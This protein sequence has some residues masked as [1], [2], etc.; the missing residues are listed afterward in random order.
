MEYTRNIKNTNFLKNTL[1][2][3]SA[4]IAIIDERGSI[5]AV[6]TAWKKFAK[7]NNYIGNDHGVGTNYFDI[8]KYGTTE[9]K[10]VAKEIVQ[11][12]KDV[13]KD[14]NKLYQKEYPCNS[15]SEKRWFI[16]KATR[17]DEGHNKRAVIAHENITQQKQAI[18]DLKKTEQKL[19]LHFEQT[20]LAIIEWDKNFC[21]TDW[22]PQAEKIFGYTKKFAIGK[23]ASELL[24]EK[25]YF[26]DVNREGKIFLK[27]KKSIQS[28]IPTRTKNG[29]EIICQWYNTPL[30]DP[31][32]EVVGSASMI[33]DITER[34]NKDKAIQ[35]LNRKLQISN[36]ELEDF[37][38]VASHD[39][40][41]PLRKVHMFSDRIMTKYAENLPPEGQDYFKRM[42][43]AVTRMHLL[44]NDLLAFSRVASKAKPYEKVDLNE[45][46]NEVIDDLEVRIKETNTTIDKTD[47]PTI[48]A[49]AMQMRQLIQNLISNAIKFKKKNASPKIKLSAKIIKKADHPALNK[50]IKYCEISVA[51]NGIGFNVKYLDKIFTVFQRLHGNNEYEGSGIGLAVCRKIAERHGGSITATSKEGK[52]SVFYVTLP[53]H[54]KN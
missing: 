51:D 24:F 29:K 3:L 17:F 1:N 2:A 32:G 4:H 26:E 39:L 49:D 45:L 43:N 52:G 38:S 27:D 18:E 34:V 44:I 12:I 31:S 36:R 48:D 19:H 41:E 13:L 10:K 21:V 50:Q 23:H 6:N 22:N 16:L 54:Q 5:L 20:P 37:A 42:Q 7:D 28:I 15:P 11:G 30:V 46:T 33:E 8:D 25:R 35:D 47:L 53:L 14:K 9:E 40:Q